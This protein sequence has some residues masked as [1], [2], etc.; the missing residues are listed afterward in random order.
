MGAEWARCS[1]SNS[2]LSHNNLTNIW[3]ILSRMQFRYWSYFLWTY[4]EMIGNH[5]TH[6][7]WLGLSL[8]LCLSGAVLWE[9]AGA[10]GQITIQLKAQKNFTLSM[11]PLL[12]VPCP[13]LST[14]KSLNDSH[15]SDTPP[16]L[17]T[18]CTKEQGRKIR[19]RAAIKCEL[20]LGCAYFGPSLRTLHVYIGTLTSNI[21]VNL[22]C[23][24]SILRF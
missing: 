24:Y 8:S 9:R 23:I 18:T 19:R 3:Y 1:H 17:F 2:G 7:L 6:R 10:A 12:V 14:Q 21:L 5:C 22:E 16:R 20:P 13:P 4:C 11:P 15:A